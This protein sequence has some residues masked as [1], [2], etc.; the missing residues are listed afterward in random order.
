MQP[1]SDTIRLADTP[2]HPTDPSMPSRLET[3]I[4]NLF[5]AQVEKDKR[6]KNA[7][8]LVH[9]ARQ[10]V[11][12]NMAAGPG[13]SSPP[14]PDDPNYM[15][16]VG[17]LFTAVIAARLHEEGLLNFEDAITRYLDDELTRGL[18]VYKG[19]DYTDSIQIRH[20]LNQTSGLPDNFYPLFDKMLA[21]P[22][23]VITPREAVLWA[24][25]HLRPQAPPGKRS[26]YTDTNYHLLGLIIEQV[27]QE[28]FHAVL[29]RLIFE[30]LGMKRSWMLHQS[31]PEVPTA[32]AEAGFYFKQTRL[33]DLPGFAG[34]DYAGGGVTAPM[35]DLLVFM[36]AL[37]S[38]KLVNE[39]TLGRMLDDKAPLYPGWHY[40]YAIWQVQPIALLIPAKYRS[41]G[42][43]G[44]TG[45]FLFYHPQL[46]AYIAGTF[47]HSAWQRKCVRFMYRIMNLLHKHAA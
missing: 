37:T 32:R 40:G 21:D 27:C 38:H 15:A 42:V 11:H 34:V 3:S 41:W 45:A 10:S 5:L 19:T 18:H 13:E 7:C 1:Y 30:P 17:K 16:S 8:L 29:R 36:Q 33:N 22:T 31:T 4:E 44:A 20:L 24:K 25:E 43:L 28:P 23:F 26:Y 35:E 39:Q 46:E 2:I 6:L 12:V 9:S 47:N 14:Q